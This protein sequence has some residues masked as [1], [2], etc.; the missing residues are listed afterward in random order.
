[1]TIKVYEVNREGHIRILREEAEVK[2]LD[3]PEPSDR[4]PAC[5]CPRCL[6]GAR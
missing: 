4:F 6:N 3:R 1:M 5:E 2:P